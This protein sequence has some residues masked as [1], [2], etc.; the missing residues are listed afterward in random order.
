MEYRIAV[1][2]GESKREQWFEARGDEHSLEQETR[3]DSMQGRGIKGAGG[4]LR[5]QTTQYGGG[6]KKTH[7]HTRLKN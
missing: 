4:C 7:N 1:K 3:R 5:G 6:G 2:I